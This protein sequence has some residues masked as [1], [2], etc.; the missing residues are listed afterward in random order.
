[1]LILTLVQP[2][3]LLRRSANI[4]FLLVTGAGLLMLN[5][6]GHTKLASW[7]WVIAIGALVSRRAYTTGGISAPSI[8]LFFF[9]SMVAG[10]LLGTR[11]GAISALVLAGVGLAFVLVE[12]ANAL[13]AA[14]VSFTPEELWLFSCMSLALTVVL[15][16]QITLALSGS[17]RRAEAEILAR[18]QAEQRLQVAL[19]AGNVGVWDQDFES[20]RFTADAN[21]LQALRLAERR[22]RVPNLARAGPS[23]GP[24][25]RGGRP[26]RAR[27]WD[28][29]MLEWSFA[30][31]SPMV[32]SDTWIVPAAP[33]ATNAVKSRR[34][35]ESPGTLPLKNMR[36]ASACDSCMTSRNASKSSSCS[37]R[38]RVCLQQERPLDH[39]LFRELVIA[40]ADRVAV[41]GVLRG[42]DCIWRHRR[43]HTGLEG[44]AM[45]PE[46]VIFDQPRCLGRD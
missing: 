30:S 21:V 40:N 14:A 16:E 12:R 45:A 20:G 34:S 26:S 43:P 38:R 24:P 23:R 32:S 5:R 6:R 17:L 42:A 3:T 35:S 11:G 22:R 25:A 29:R 2:Q 27:E 36:N 41:S 10:V 39:A 44:I 13:P 33:S 28:S 15:H 7:L 9:V 37:I 31:C 18:R 1:M 19:E 46:P 8:T 4:A